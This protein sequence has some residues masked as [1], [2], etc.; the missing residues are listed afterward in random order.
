M[1]YVA[2]KKAKSQN[3]RGMEAFASKARPTSMM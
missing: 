1:R 2:V 3:L